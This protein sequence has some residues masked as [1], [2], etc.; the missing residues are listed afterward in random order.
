MTDELGFD[1]H[2]VL[3]LEISPEDE[4]Y[5]DAL[6]PSMYDE[7]EPGTLHCRN[8]E[9]KASSP[10]PVNSE[11]KATNSGHVKSPSFTGQT[12]YSCYVGGMTWWT[13]DEDLLELIKAIGIVDVID[14]LIHIN[15]ANGQSKGFAAVTCASEASIKTVMEQI[16]GKAL[17]NQLL[18]VHSYTRANLDK[19]D[20][21]TRKTIPAPTNDKASISPG[22]KGVKF[23][24]TVNLATQQPQRLPL[25][26]GLAG[27]HQ[28]P[29]YGVAPQGQHVHVNPLFYANHQSAPVVRPKLTESDLMKV[30]ER[31]R[32]V[33]SSAVS[34][35]E[36]YASE[37][38]YRSAAETVQMA[39]ALIGQ[40]PAA[41]E[42]E[43]GHLLSALNTALHKYHEKDIRAMSRLVRLFPR[44]V[45]VSRSY[46]ASAAAHTESEL[47]LT[48]ASPDQALF[49][50]RVVKQVDVPTLAGTVGV[51]ASHVPTLGVLKPGVV[52]VTDLDGTTTRM[53]VSSGTLSV[54]IDGSV[55][56]LAEEVAKI[57]DIDE[58]LARQEL[59][60]AQRKAAEGGSEVDRAEALIR[61]ETAEALLKAVSEKH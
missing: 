52:T 9:D 6:A 15:R 7:P 4:L 26:T 31:N 56:V 53:F 38:D 46:A 32:T 37:G 28:Q 58:S 40:S 3:D 25:P 27:F 50:D 5:D 45:Q 36:E 18:H 43:C 24:G 14:V 23:L 60:A 39:A 30:M 17:N 55:Q 42:P 57:E 41:Y 47:R 61:S 12:R 59:D 35:A 33:S 19:L 34:R 51:L 21:V 1:A 13:T 49:T 44:L 16:P 22:D 48:F 54:N 2:N 29:V 20:T 8:S 11:L 10:V